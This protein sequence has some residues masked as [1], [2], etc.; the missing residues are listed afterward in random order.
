MGERVKIILDDIKASRE[1]ITTIRPVYAWMTRAEAQR[2]MQDEVDPAK[3]P[4]VILDLLDEAKAE[5]P[6][7]VHFAVIY[8]KAWSMDTIAKIEAQMAQEVTQKGVQWEAFVRPFMPYSLLKTF[9]AGPGHELETKK[10]RALHAE[11]QRGRASPTGT[12]RPAVSDA[13][14]RSARD[15]C[16][17]KGVV[18]CVS[19]SLRGVHRAG[20][21]CG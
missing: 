9:E 3:L 20:V 16:S 2:A 19:W 18:R 11:T 10:R 1:W 8:D 12:F 6:T 13:R 17:G 4:E 15:A 5:D 7:I 21:Y 14:P